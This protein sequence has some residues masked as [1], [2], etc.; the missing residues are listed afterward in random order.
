MIPFYIN[1][2]FN[3]VI[4]EHKKTRQILNLP[5]TH[6]T[7]ILHH[8]LGSFPEPDRHLL[9]TSNCHIFDQAAPY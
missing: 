2:L 3:K 6:Y 5:K 8:Y 9:S 1:S 7:L 4:F